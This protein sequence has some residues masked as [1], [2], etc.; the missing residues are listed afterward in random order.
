MYYL[1]YLRHFF[2]E[3]LL[4]GVYD[5]VSPIFGE[6]VEYDWLEPAFKAAIIVAALLLLRE[7]Y[8]R[9]RQAYTR[10]KIWKSMEGHDVREP[11][12]AKDTSFIEEIDVAQHPIHTLE[13]LKKEKRY[14]RIGEALAKLNRPEEAARWFLKDKQ[15]DRAAAELARAGKTLKAAR[16]LKRTGDYE[17]AARFYAAAGKHKQAA[18]ICMKQD[19]ISGAGAI[20]VEGGYYEKGAACFLEYFTN[21][22]DPPEKQEAVADRCYQLLRSSAFADALPTLQ[23]N[24]LLNAVA[25]RFRAA[26]RNA[27]AARVFQ[28]S[29]DTLHASEMYKMDTPNPAPRNHTPP[30]K[31]ND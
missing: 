29:G 27:L 18:A 21:T 4:G 13:Q 23:R 16:L 28:E 19:D 30:P 1:K 24:A 15:Y 8:L 26:G 10:H 11:Y 9:A 7:I 25:Q 5:A 14:G 6:A 17:T 3:R 22:G 20:Y 31:E 2:W 12:T